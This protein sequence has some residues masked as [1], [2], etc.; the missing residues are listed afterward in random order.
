MP[1]LRSSR[2]NL[3]VNRSLGISIS[4]DIMVGTR[5]VPKYAD[6]EKTQFA[7]HRETG[8]KLCTIAFFFMEEDRA[9]AL[10]ITGPETGLPNGLRPGRPVKPVELFATSWERIFNR[11][12]PADQMTAVARL[13]HFSGL[14]TL[15]LSIARNAEL[16][17][18]AKRE[19]EPLTVKEGRQ[20]L[21]AARDNRLWAAYEPAVRIGL[22]RVSC[23][24]SAGRTWTFTKACSRFGR[25]YRASAVSC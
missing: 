12:L 7:T 22:Q 19:I 16:S 3:K 21:A 15:A 14:P 6:T 10:K 1:S 2:Q 9:E 25:P 13:M 17:M 11:G 4:P 8:T 5:P 24:G 20:L 18:G 23:W